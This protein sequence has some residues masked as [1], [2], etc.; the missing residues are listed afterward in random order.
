MYKILPIL[1]LL[2]SCSLTSQ[3]SMSKRLEVRDIFINQYV[4]QHSY[5][6][7]R[8]SMQV[9]FCKDGHS[10]V[11]AKHCI[12]YQSNGCL[13]MFYAKEVSLKGKI[14][15]EFTRHSLYVC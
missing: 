13:Y 7:L 9:S 2:T 3:P 10:E 12:S 8:E 4:N 1:T 11:N 5:L 15:Y 6:Q 14:D